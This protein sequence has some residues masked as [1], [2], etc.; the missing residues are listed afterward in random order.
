MGGVEPAAPSGDRVIV[1]VAFDQV[2]LLDVSGPLEVFTTAN[3]Y[4]ARYDVRVISPT[5][6]DVLTSSGLRIGADTDLEQ[7]PRHVNTLLV[8]GRSDWRQA[9]ADDVLVSL[10]GGLAARALRVASVCA[11]AF[12]LA[13]TGVLDGRRATTH[14]E[15][16][17]QLAAAFPQVRVEPDPVFV[18]DGHIVTSAGVTAGIDLAL[19]LVEEDYGADLARETARQLVVFMARPGGQSQFSIR[20]TPQPPQHRLV[21]RAMDEITADPSLPHGIGALTARLGISTRHL[22][23]LFRQEIGMTPGQY[24]DAVRVEAAQ[25]LLSSGLASVEEV[26]QQAGFGSSETMRRVFQQALG[27]SPTVYRAR[28]RTTTA[29]APAP[30]ALSLP[31]S[32]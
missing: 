8:P 32:C 10:V 9:I 11:G 3:R 13:Q 25:T 27:L 17:S 12:V 28:F 4:G 20:M 15:L 16:A 5:G 30:V 1:V 31:S 22:A 21:R 6:L 14:W 19:A 23:R 2:Q 24:A 7:L 18:R 26:A 29:P